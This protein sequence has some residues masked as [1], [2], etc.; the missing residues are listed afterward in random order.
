MT[1]SRLHARTLAFASSYSLVMSIGRLAAN[2]IRPRGRRKGISRQRYM[3]QLEARNLLALS[4]LSVGPVDGATNVLVGSNLTINFNENVIKGQGNI[5]VVRDNTGTLGQAVDVQSSAVTV[6]GSTVTVDLPNNLAYETAFSV[7]IDSGAFIDT[8]GT[9]TPGSTLLTQNFDFLPLG[10]AVFERGGDGTDFTLVPPLG[11]SI[12]NSN[13]PT[14]GVPEWSGWSFANKD[15]WAQV[16]NQRRTDFTLAKNTIAIA[17]SDEWA[18]TTP[19]G[20]GNFNSVMQ[21]KPIQ[22]AGVT[23]NTAVL[24]FDSSFRPE[25]SQIGTLDVRFDGGAWTNL[26]TLDPTTT[27][28]LGNV[29]EHRTVPVSNPATGT[30]EFRWGLIGGNDWWWGLDSIEVKAQVAGVPYTGQSDAAFWNFKTEVEPI[31]TMSIDRASMSENGGTAVGTVTRNLSTANALVVNL[32]SS[33]TTE[34]TVPATVTILSG[35]T[36]ATFPITAVDDIL[37]DRTQK[38]TITASNATFTSGSNTIDV[39]DDDGLNIIALSPADNALVADYQG[40]LSMTFDRNVRAGSGFI[41]VVKA[42]DNKLGVSVRSD[43]TAVTISGATVT[44]NPASDLVAGT[45]YYVLIDDGALV[46]VSAT[47]SPNTTLLQQNFELLPLGPFIGETGGDGTDFTKTPP[48]DYTVVG[49]AP[50]PG[51]P[52]WNSWSFADKGAWSAASANGGRADFTLG[53]GTVAVADPDAWLDTTPV[54]NYNTFLTTAPINLTNVA[55]GTAVLEFDASFQNADLGLANVDVSYNDGPWNNLTFFGGTSA[56]NTHIVINSAGVTG[57][58]AFPGLGTALSNPASGQMRFRF[59]VENAGQTGW[60]AI[61]NLRVAGTVTGISFEG[62]TDPAIWNFTAALP[63]L[64]LATTKTSIQEVGGTATGTVTRNMRTDVDLVVN[65][66]SSDTTELTVPATVTILAGQSSATF[67]ITAVNDGI[68]DGDQVAIITASASPFLSATQAINVLSVG[69]SPADDST[70]VPVGSNLV[71]T[72]DRPVEKGNGFVHIVRASDGKLGTSI[73]IRSSDVTIAGA[74]VTINP[75]AD[76]VGLTD[77]YVTL[78]AGAI[79]YT[80]ATVTAGTTLLSENFELLPLGPAVTETVVGATGQDWT[81]TA[82]AGFAVDNSQMPPGGVPEW[83]GW[84]FA[85]KSFWANAGGQGRTSFTKGLGTVAIGDTDEW[86]DLPRPSNAFNS[87]FST[88]AID[89]TKVQ[90]NTVQLEFDSSFRPENNTTIAGN[91]VGMVDVSY[92]GGTNWSNLL[93]LDPTNTSADL[94]AANID[95]HRTLIVSNPGGTGQMKFRFGLTGTNDYWWAIDN[96]KV[97]GAITGLAYAGIAD[98]TAWNFTTAEAQALTVS[99]AAGPIL[100][101][102]GTTTATVARNLG[103]TGDLVVTLSSS[104]NSVA[105]VPATVTIPSGQASATFPIT[106]VDDN[107]ADGLKN[108]HILASTTGFVTGDGLLAVTDNEVVNVVVS[109]IM[110]NPTNP[111]GSTNTQTYTEW[112]E[113][114][115][116][117]SVPADLS[118]WSFNDEDLTDWSAIPAGTLLP[119]GGVAV[120]FNGLFGTITESQFRTQ[121]NVP[122]GALVVGLPLWGN[123]DNSPS[124]TNEDFFFNDSGKQVV[125]HVDFDDDGTIWPTGTVGASIALANVALDNNNGLNWRLSVLG[126][127][128]ARNPIALPDPQPPVLYQLA[129]IGSPGQVPAITSIGNTKVY[130]KGSSFS[131]GGTN[132]AAA[133]DPNKVVAQSNANPQVLTYAN[134]INTTRGIN[135]LVLDV[136]GLS[137]TSL[138][139][140][141]FVFRV[142]PTGVFDE[143]A[144]PPSSWATAPNNAP[145]P[146]AITVIPGSP[147][148]VLLEWP[149]NAIANRWL[150]VQVLPTVNTGLSSTQ[151]FYLGHLQGELDGSVV[152]GAY[153]VLNSDLVLVLPIGVATVDSI[154]D[155]DKSGFVL[156]ADGVAIR[157]SLGGAL[158]NITIP[159]AGSAAEGAVAPAPPIL[160]PIS[161]GGA[162]DALR[163]A[164]L[165]STSTVPDSISDKSDR[166]KATPFTGNAIAS[167]LFPSAT[168]DANMLVCLPH[169]VAVASQSPRRADASVGPQSVGPRIDSARFAAP[170][171][172]PT[173]SD[174]LD[175]ADDFFAELESSALK[176]NLLF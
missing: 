161:V 2:R 85:N 12:D 17:D 129:D 92:D 14:G 46:D 65:L 112:V 7:Y 68:S 3:E 89:L 153:R 124:P 151:V 84:T 165:M 94:T 11:F 102:G 45:Q 127:G 172:S 6:S 82:P 120:I 150:Q 80:E 70:A 157:N 75:P 58:G 136:A 169:T 113:L 87:I 132:V 160:A 20:A 53:A 16:D 105:T 13:M 71:I 61:D 56:R 48:L 110:F 143:A 35:Q 100:E 9:P 39:T 134:L 81:A 162:E 30:M 128:S 36:S 146:S 126:T 43:S 57:A 21:S 158:R 108:V 93:T 159:V 135:G 170:S 28:N 154:R 4:I 109:E 156:N 40:N 19:R 73:D 147:A 72:F 69:L 171:P 55:A 42:S 137:A 38:V 54:G 91:Q 166:L 22:L 37:P 149:D 142:S 15:F 74:V 139:A 140:A 29:N 97:T 152:A 27:T 34:A 130:Y 66:S 83:K 63:A 115:N 95:E 51:N 67:Q 78:D 24:E 167:S 86:D 77:Y 59:S 155:V 144:N 50:T 118:G 107:V 148:R 163:G 174:L 168:N 125:D 175:V 31:L 18:D 133:L 99:F 8:S 32:T 60:F 44:I 64:S 1:L 41:H 49:S 131:A 33:D 138:T 121:W 25:D 104:D 116:R 106:L 111:T 101:N 98:T 23:A 88:S 26:L 103:T 47:V 10:P 164:S 96:L 141:D 145:A 52:E 62:I 176:G 122:A 123:L 119:A 76:L 5:H 79:V 90:P 117:G 114:V 173:R